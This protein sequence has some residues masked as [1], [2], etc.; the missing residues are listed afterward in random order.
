MLSSTDIQKPRNQNNPIFVF[1]MSYLY[2]ACRLWLSIYVLLT[3][4]KKKEGA[5]FNFV[6]VFLTQIPCY[7]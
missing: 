4:E 7:T 5:A 6:Y 2:P 1:S 3:K